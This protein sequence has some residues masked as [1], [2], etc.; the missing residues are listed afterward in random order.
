M[1]LKIH[2]HLVP[3]QAN[4]ILLYLPQATIP[5]KLHMLLHKL[6]HILEV[7][8]DQIHQEINI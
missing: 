3:N 6:V 7:M 4:Q 8:A 1:V 5:N 2:L